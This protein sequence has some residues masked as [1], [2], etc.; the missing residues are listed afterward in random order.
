MEFTEVP[1]EQDSEPDREERIKAAYI[2][3]GFSEE[4]ATN[5]A[6]EIIRRQKNQIPQRV[7]ECW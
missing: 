3:A 5:F 7:M 1:Y 6:R 4:D 2:K